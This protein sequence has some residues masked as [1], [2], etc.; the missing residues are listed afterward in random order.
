VWRELTAEQLITLKDP[1]VIDVR[2][3]CEHEAERLPGSKN[4]P[5]LSNE[6][7]AIIGTIYKEDGEVIARRHALKLIAPKIP[8]I[9]DD[10]CALR[11]L[12]SQATV[13]YCWRG[14]LRSES[15]ASLLSMA[16]IDCFRLQGGYK[17]WRGVVRRELDSD[18]YDFIPVVLHGL[19][20]V[21]KT[22]LL[23]ELESRSGKV[24]DL[25]QLASHRGSAFGGM[26]LPQQPTQKNFD[27]EI[28][29]KLREFGKNVVFMEAES[30]RVGRISLPDCVFSRINTGAAV[31][32]TGSLE[33]R[34]ERI[35]TDYFATNEPNQLEEALDR[36]TGLKES[37]GARKIS[38]IKK[39]VLS[40]DLHAAVRMLLVEYYDPLYMKQIRSR[41]PFQLEI[42]GDNSALAAER[43]LAWINESLLTSASSGG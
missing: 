40:G 29:K 9:I 13:V 30:R 14:G 20:G 12:H 18:K 31:L 35:L 27:A 6:E 24:L 25:E 22:E 15:V 4:I 33:K 34:V 23:K 41:S 39:T 36:L 16:G 3:P 19:T 26:G 42:C 21:G 43:L 10:I 37:I 7:R 28:W 11:T 38:E 1:L 8:S 17:S 2:S 5:L 32:V